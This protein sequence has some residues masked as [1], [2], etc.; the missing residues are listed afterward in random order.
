MTGRQAFLTEMVVSRE[1][2]A[3][4]IA[5]NSSLV[6]GARLVG[7]ALAGLL[8]ARTSAG[9]CF[10]VNGIS[11]LAVLAA[12]LA[13]HVAPRGRPTEKRDLGRGLREG[14]AYA[15]GFAPI[16]A[17]LLLLSLVSVAGTSYSVLLPVFATDVLHGRQTTL[18][19]LSAAAGVGAL[20]GAG[21]LAARKSVVGLG[22]WI[23]GAPAFFGLGLVAFSFSDILWVSLA[24]L[25]VAG[26]AMM[27]HMAASN[28]V[29]QTIVDED[30]R[31]R[32]MSLYVM[33]FLG[34]MPLGSLLAGFLSD[35]IGAPATLRVGGTICIAGAVVFS[36]RFGQLRAQ[37]R[38]IYVRIGILP[39]IA[40]GIQAATELTRPPE[41]R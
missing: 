5:L 13:M 9:V 29:L 11:Y 28:T 7:P 40:G 22:R 8:L 18:G 12:L 2:L 23:T 38:P 3:N 39:E 16:R 34:M 27:V 17:I 19:L 33:A 15:F 10:L 21:F 41:E 25:V 35:R 20:V 37:V 36:L 14:L 24:L 4:A 1:D 6:N 26:F 32:V 30:K 31:G